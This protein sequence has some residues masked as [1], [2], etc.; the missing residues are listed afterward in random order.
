LIKLQE[1]YVPKDISIIRST[2]YRHIFGKVN[3]RVDCFEDVKILNDAMQT[4]TI[5]GNKTWFAITWQ[6]VGGRLAVLNVEKDK[7]RVQPPIQKGKTEA[8]STQVSTIEAGSPLIDFDFSPHND[9][10]I[11][12]GSSYNSLHSDG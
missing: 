5:R 3:N 12:T 7:G 2:H 9:A 8:S 11:A 1:Y 6:G 10:I 4:H